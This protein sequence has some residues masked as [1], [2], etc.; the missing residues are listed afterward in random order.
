MEPRILSVKTLGPAVAGRA[1]RVEIRVK[2]PLAAINGVQADFGDAL[3]AV[4][5]SACRPR[6]SFTSPFRPGQAVTFVLAHAYLLPGEYDL[7]ITATSGDCVIGPLMSRRHL[8]VKVRTPRPSDLLPATAS[9]ANGCPGANTLPAKWRTTL[10]LANAVRADRG[11]K[12]LKSSR[13]LRL[14]SAAH[15]RDMVANGY[16]A[17]RSPRGVDFIDRLRKARYRAAGAAENLGAGS[18]VLATPLA[19]MIAWMESPPHRA[20]LLEADYDE[21]GVGVAAG[22]PAGGDGATY[23]MALAHR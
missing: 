2:D 14:A 15:A 21:A 19:M 6:G 3:G 7:K 11:L 20:N 1:V 16:F 10:C 17:H 12:R 23:A 4:K 9:Q 13:R 5:Q 18:D 22:F 8:R